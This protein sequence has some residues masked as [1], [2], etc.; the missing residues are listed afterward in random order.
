MP[1]L[2][3]LAAADKFASVT[4]A[5]T[6]PQLESPWAWLAHAEEGVRFAFFITYH[7]LRRLAARLASDRASRGPAVT[8]AQRALAQHHLAFRDLQAVLLGVT[9]ALFDQPPAPEEWPVRTTLRHIIGAEAGFLARIKY[10]VERVRTGDS[11][12]LEMPDDLLP[13][14][15]GLDTTVRE[16]LKSAPLPDLWAWF[17]ALHDR[18]LH[19]LADIE[20]VELD[21]PSLWWEE[22]DVPVEFRLHRFD[23]HLRQHT[24]QIEKTLAAINGAPTEARRLLR[25]IYSSLAE[26][27]GVIVGA[28]DFGQAQRDDAAQAIAARADDIANVIGR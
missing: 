14:Y 26:V 23:A 24:I 27:E 5:L 2:S 28:W 12:P 18:A 20:N 13:R 3:L 1:A 19:E 21:A 7:E 6:E 15:T 10:A 9:N 11:R 22:Y 25:H 17:S 8:L 16:R 4:H